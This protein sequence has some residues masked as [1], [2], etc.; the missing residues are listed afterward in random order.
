MRLGAD[1]ECELRPIA[2]TRPRG[3]DRAEDEALEAELM[4]S[5]RSGPST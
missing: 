4:A 2:G 1:G 5:E 3:R